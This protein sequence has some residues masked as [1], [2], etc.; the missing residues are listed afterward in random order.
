MIHRAVFSFMAVA[1]AAF[2]Q[3]A[4]EQV[5]R[6]AVAMSYELD[7]EQ[8]S[9]TVDGDEIRVDIDGTRQGD[10]RVKQHD[11]WVEICDRD[12]VPVAGA[13]RDGRSVRLE[14]FDQVRS[15]WLGVDL[16]PVEEALANHLGLDRE[17]VA[18]VAGVAEGSPAAQ[19]GLQQ[20]DI[21][22]RFDG[23]EPATLER[24]R[25]ILAER[26]PGDVLPIAYL[27]RGESNEIEARLAR[28]RPGEGGA[29]FP[30]SVYQAFGNQ[31]NLAWKLNPTL[32]TLVQGEYLQPPANLSTE[33]WPLFVQGLQGQ[34][35]WDFPSLYGKLKQAAEPAPEKVEDGLR[36]QLDE[37]RQQIEALQETLRKLTEQ[38]RKE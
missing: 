4:Q 6:P 17:K 32:R 14:F 25:E 5:Q 13:H 3:D 27:R 20:H 11:G 22:V 34:K 10:D 16:T 24:L 15:A 33:Q 31:P 7:G 38:Q 21:L 9:I 1:A 37:L 35:V 12:G 30:Y 23:E 19:A 8:V 29:S 2:A 26:R 36:G 18:L 28:A